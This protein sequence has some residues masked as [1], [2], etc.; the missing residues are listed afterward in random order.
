MSQLRSLRQSSAGRLACKF[1]KSS[2]HN[3]LFVPTA[4]RAGNWLQGRGSLA[5]V[6]AKKDIHPK[7]YDEVPVSKT[8][9]L[10]VCTLPLCSGGIGKN[11]CRNRKPHHQQESE[12][13]TPKTRSTEV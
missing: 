6:R 3:D 10:H 13:H 8:P 7:Y 11:G 2:A 5:V 4:N 12:V 1:S 9:A